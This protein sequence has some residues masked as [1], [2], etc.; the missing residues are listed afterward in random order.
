MERNM[1]FETKITLIAQ[2]IPVNSKKINYLNKK[3]KK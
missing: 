1:L 3:K 2:F